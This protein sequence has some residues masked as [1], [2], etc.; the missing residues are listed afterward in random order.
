MHDHAPD[1]D[2]SHRHS[3]KHFWLAFAVTLGF[4]GLEAL[5]GAFAHSLALLGDAGHMATDSIALLLAG[6][7]GLMAARPASHRHSYGFGRVEVFAALINT[8]LMLAIVAGIAIEGV[9]RLRRPEPVHA[10]LVIGVGLAGLL[11]NYLIYRVVERGHASLNV[12]ATLLHVLSDMLGSGAALVAGLVVQFTG[13]LPID[14]LLS[15]FIALLILISSLRLLRDAGQVLLE[16]VPPG[17]DLEDIGRSMAGVEG[18]GS[19]HDLH[20][21]CVS[22]EEVALSAHVVIEDMGL[23]EAVFQGLRAHLHD[24]YGIEHI[25]LQ[26]EP[27]VKARIRPSEIARAR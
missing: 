27:R 3:Q 11:V 2:H 22:S 1:H 13:W 5:A 15:L 4:A 17:M 20:V 21:W 14:P 6:L 23:W 24:S 7:A 18:V 16:G 9:A 8:L 19:I 25:T 12:R 10:P 26:P